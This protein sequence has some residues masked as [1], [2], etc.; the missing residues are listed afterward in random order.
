MANPV[1]T[2]TLLPLMP[3]TDKDPCERIQPGIIDLM[4]EIGRG[5]SWQYKVNGELSAEFIAMIQGLECVGGGVVLPC[6]VVALA[7]TATPGNTTLA[8]SF[9]GS[10]MVAGYDWNLYRSVTEDS[11]LDP[12]IQTGVT[13]GSVITYN[14]TGLVNGTVYYYRLTVQKPTCDI[15]TVDITGTPQLCKTLLLT[16]GVISDRPGHTKITVTGNLENTYTY[17]LY[18]SNLPNQIGSV[19]DTGTVASHPCTIN[20]KL[21]L[22]L[23]HDVP[24]TGIPGGGATWNYT[25]KIQEQPACTEYELS[26]SVFVNDEALDKPILTFSDL[27]F[28]WGAVNGATGYAL[29]ARRAGTCKNDPNFSVKAT[30]ATTSYAF[31]LD[32]FPCTENF[33]GTI[34]VSKWEVYV[35]AYGSNGKSS[36]PSDTVATPEF[37]KFSGQCVG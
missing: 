36:P 29:Y 6:P 14:D 9:N 17:T 10:R 8:L 7:G 37:L 30:L 23:E 26:Q 35:V 24:L 1:T 15:Y 12:A 4:S 32:R 2:E 27:A 25:L 28:R 5:Y 31:S 20:G 16:M 3:T 34:C 18:G 11:F 13:T 22:C 21:A 19:L 33:S